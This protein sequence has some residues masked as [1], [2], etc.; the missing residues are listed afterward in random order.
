MDQHWVD[1]SCL[2]GTCFSGQ[3][4]TH[5]TVRSHESR[6]ASWGCTRDIEVA[7]DID[8]REYIVIDLCLFILPFSR[9]TAV[10]AYLKS[11][12]LLLLSFALYSC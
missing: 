7:E 1:I 3:A 4:L 6:F 12:L 8:G 9:Q 2:L 10:T 5:D 11:E